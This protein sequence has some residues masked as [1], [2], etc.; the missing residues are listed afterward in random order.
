MK[1][2]TEKE[3]LEV[4][5]K[6]PRIKRAQTGTLTAI[7]TDGDFVYLNRQLYLDS[8][9]ILARAKKLKYNGE[10]TYSATN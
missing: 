5:A 9:H 10:Y 2:A 8:L 6:Y 4:A 7:T 1:Y 3:I